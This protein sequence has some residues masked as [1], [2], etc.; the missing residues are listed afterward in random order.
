M[1]FNKLL[2]LQLIGHI[3][4]DFLFQSDQDAKE[5]NGS[6]F[7]S[8]YLKWHILIIFS[9]SWIL[10]FQ[11]YFIIASIFITLLHWIIDGLK[12]ELQKV[13][14]LGKFT[15]FIDQLLHIAVIY[16]ITYLFTVLFKINPILNI[17][18]STHY[19]IIITGYLLCAKPSNVFVK[20]IIKLFNISVAKTE[21]SESSLPNAGKLI[22][23]IERWLVLT[24]ILLNQ[25]EP[26]G[27][28]IAAKSIL[29]F[30]DDDILKTEY[31]VVGTMLSFGIAI[32][33]GLL[34]IECNKNLAC[35]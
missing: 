34:I 30:K 19:L 13:S 31:V 21:S 5:K 7:K 20:E 10:S 35:C 16:L 28:L 26:I 17:G 27:F 15:F 12:K 3:L 9:F 14:A 18:I 2:V 25:Y 23:I 29:R 1:D 11:L 32:A 8:K 33:I 6:G 24:F 4:A 22:G